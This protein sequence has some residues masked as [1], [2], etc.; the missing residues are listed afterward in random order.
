M[1]NACNS[2][3][4]SWRDI[5]FAAAAL[6]F[7]IVF[8]AF[9]LLLII[10]DAFYIDRKAVLTVINSGFIR[11]AL[12]MS[13]WTSCLTTLIA[14]LFAVPIGY[15]LSRYRFPGRALADT[16][17]DLPIVFPPLVAGL[18]LLVFFSQT[19]F[20]KWIQNDLGIEFVFRK[21][22]IILC[23]FLVSASFAI[24]SAKI[25]FDEVDRRF[26]NVALTLGCTRFRA[27]R[28]VSLPLAL[29]GVIAGAILTWARAF[30]LFGPL[31]IFVGS[32]RGRTE[33]LSTTVFLEQSVGNIEVALAVAMLMIVV[34]VIAL[35][36]I[37]L[38][39]GRTQVKL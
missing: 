9:V 33:V 35:T 27:F 36:T 19:D 15:S 10:A 39:G 20:G 29:N 22:G 37:H 2:P 18:T 12:W 34:A 1:S 3:L 17:V 6:A 8:V 28:R 26:E 25:A 31:L 13:L 16:I 5:V 30:G 23:Q 21:K 14:V 24:R 7:L 38:V 4:R 11:H 32:F